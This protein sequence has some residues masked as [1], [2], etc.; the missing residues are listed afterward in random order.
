MQMETWRNA[1]L[2]SIF[3]IY[4]DKRCCLEK[5]D[6]KWYQQWTSI[7]CLAY[8]GVYILAC[9]VRK[10]PYFTDAQVIYPSLPGES[11]WIRSDFLFVKICED[12]K[13]FREEN[14]AAVTWFSDP[15][16]ADPANLRSSL[17]SM[18]CLLGVS[19]RRSFT[20]TEQ[21]HL[22]FFLKLNTLYIIIRL[23]I[24]LFCACFGY[25]FAALSNK[26]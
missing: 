14:S 23:Y 16:W 10:S 9:W 20:P 7:D 18:M 13:K 2:R 8:A 22:S 24:D 25:L 15:P 17:A 26:N 12:A 1:K 6:R 3:L 11:S 4:L 5:G 19:V 21:Q